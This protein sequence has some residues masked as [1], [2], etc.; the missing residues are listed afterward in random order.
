MWKVGA[1]V[2]AGAA[3]FKYR[4]EIKDI[5]LNTAQRSALDMAAKELAKGQFESLY[6]ENVKYMADWMDLLQATVKKKANVT[7]HLLLLKSLAKQAKGT[8][9]S[10]QATLLEKKHE[11]WNTILL[12]SIVNYFLSLH[13]VTLWYCIMQ[14]CRALQ[15]SAILQ[16]RVQSKDGASSGLKKQHWEHL[17]AIVTTSLDAT[18]H[19]IRQCVQS[20]LVTLS[21]RIDKNEIFSKKA[22][23][24]GISDIHW[25]ILKQVSRRSNCWLQSSTPSFEY[26]G[27]EYHECDTA[28]L[29]ECVYVISGAEF[30]A[31]FTKCVHTC[32]M[33]S[34][35]RLGSTIADDGVQLA[36]LAVQLKPASAQVFEVQGPTALSSLVAEPTMV[37]FCSGL[38][39]SS[40]TCA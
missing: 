33:Q 5:L 1:I 12:E 7:K 37:S 31:L 18:S 38:A 9:N 6:K 23:V 19:L 39:D 4:T 34:V 22:V 17:W 24:D 25:E 11:L 8:E 28:L 40:V 36:K 3:A 10:Q 29:K 30:N 35:S 26:R 27:T 14:V 13:T 16:D 2:A 32:V 21:W 15:G 20:K